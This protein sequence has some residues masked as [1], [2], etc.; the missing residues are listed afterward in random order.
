M[1]APPK[2]EFPS[3]H[4]RRF[5]ISEEVKFIPTPQI[6]IINLMHDN[7]QFGSAKAADSV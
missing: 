5:S 1:I 4:Y 7:R 3:S 6:K 2:V